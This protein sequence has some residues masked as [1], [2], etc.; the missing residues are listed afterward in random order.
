M[1]AIVAAWIGNLDDAARYFEKGALIDLNNSN[2][3]VSGG[4]FIGGIHTAAAGALWQMIVFGL[5]HFR[6]ENDAVY[7]APVCLPGWQSYR[8][9][10]NIRGHHMTCTVKPDILKVQGKE[11]ALQTSF[12][13]GGV[14]K[15]LFGDETLTFELPL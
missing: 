12:V 11:K 2:R 7:M 13:V 4:T 9:N 14:K 6:Y 15:T 5:A 3:A 10:L 8:F 1:H